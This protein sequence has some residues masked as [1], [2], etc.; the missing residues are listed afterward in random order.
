MALLGQC[1]EGF[2]SVM[3][4]K[5][6]E[7]FYEEWSAKSSQAI[8][9][10]IAASVRKVDVIVS[11]IPQKHLE[12][13]SSVMDFG[14][15]YGAVLH[16]FQE[17]LPHVDLAV[18]VDFSE[19]AI[20]LAKQRF[21]HE[22]LKYHKL[23]ALDIWDNLSFLRRIMPDGVDCMLLVDLLEHVP[24]CKTLVSELAAFTRYFIV[25]LPIESSAF[26]NY[27][28][29]KE[30]PSPTHSNGHL[31]EFDANNVYYFVRKLGMTP[32]FE[33]LYVYHPDDTFPPLPASCSGRQKMVR[34]LLRGFK[35]VT[36][37]I[38]PRKIFLRWVG[39]GGYFCIA[40]FDR[41]HILN[42]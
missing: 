24:D 37:K 33:S 31:R 11:S 42:P 21:E 16:R 26:D 17:R 39:G 41:S 30:Y 29:P 6:L 28:L 32:L 25:K 15:G 35:L 36:A 20:E 12:G 27:I 4:D 18:G 34:W 7:R 40:T 19:S 2:E 14:C 10:D 5:G 3:E 13:M 23:P 22:S 9:Y 8:D 38:L 1:P